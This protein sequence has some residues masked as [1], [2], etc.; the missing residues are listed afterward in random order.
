M[1]NAV[2]I[3]AS[4]AVMW[5]VPE[6]HSPQALAAAE[7]WAETRTRLL[8]PCLL[9]AELTNALY[10][11]V[12][13]EEVALETAQAALRIIL[14]FDIEIREEPGLQARAMRLAHRL[15]QPA[16]YD[17]QYLAL[18]E[19]HQCELWTGD[20]RLHA[21]AVSTLPRVRWIGEYTST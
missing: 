12:V 6:R 18:A 16:A 14:G 2:V 21:A 1:K 9:L 15:R 13:R 11:R 5:V 4:L 3:D 20:L 19:H 17:G 7:R 10:K 8:A